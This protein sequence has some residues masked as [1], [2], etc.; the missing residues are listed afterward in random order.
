MDIP[1]TDR[2]KEIST[3]FEKKD[4]EGLERLGLVVAG[5]EGAYDCAAYVM[6]RLNMPGNEKTLGVL[7]RLPNLLSPPRGEGIIFY[8]IHDRSKYVVNH[9]GWYSKGKVIS[10]WGHWLAFQH[11]IPDVPDWYGDSAVFRE[12]DAEMMLT[13]QNALMGLDLDY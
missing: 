11:E 5:D 3:L 10:K 2:R 7:R 8:G 4:R 6:K 1:I 9:Y 13:L 12:R